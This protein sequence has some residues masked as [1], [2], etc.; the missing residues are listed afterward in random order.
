[1]RL[2]W[3]CNNAAISWT[4]DVPL[5]VELSL[6]PFDRGLRGGAGKVPANISSQF[7]IDLSLAPSLLRQEA[8]MKAICGTGLRINRKQRAVR[9]VAQPQPLEP[10]VQFVRRAIADDNDF[11]RPAQV[12]VNHFKHPGKRERLLL[13]EISKQLQRPLRGSH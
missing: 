10:S 6:E 5:I 4:R 11:D 13:D 9:Q 3:R 1:M 2:S 7:A 12:E 8:T